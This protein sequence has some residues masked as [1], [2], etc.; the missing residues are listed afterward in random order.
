V[1]SSH[2]SGKQPKCIGSSE[3]KHL[4][5]LN[6]LF[7]LNNCFTVTSRDSAEI[8]RDFFVN[9]GVGGGRGGDGES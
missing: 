8:L 4:S 3:R 2:I 9:G 7:H 5:H 6:E 1:L